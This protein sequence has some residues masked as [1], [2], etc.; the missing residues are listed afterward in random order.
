MECLNWFTPLNLACLQCKL[1]FSFFYFD[2]LDSHARKMNV[3]SGYVQVFRKASPYSIY[4]LL[5]LLLTYLLNQLCRYALPIVAKEMAQEIH[6]GDKVYFYVFLPEWIVGVFPILLA[7]FVS[8]KA[9]MLIDGQPSDY[10]SKCADLNAT[11]YIVWF[12]RLL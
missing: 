8:R 1:H 2:F 9:C 5:I 6:F 12:L 3:F 10:S 11:R 7:H 4:V